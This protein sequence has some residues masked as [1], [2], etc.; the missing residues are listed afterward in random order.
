MTCRQLYIFAVWAVLL[1]GLVA[2]DHSPEKKTTV[3]VVP[4]VDNASMAEAK[5]A[6]LAARDT[7]D[8]RVRWDVSRSPTAESQ[9]ELIG[10]LVAAGVDGILISCIDAEAEVL[11]EAIDQAVA[12]GVKVGTFDSD[13]PQSGRSFYIGSDNS[14]A[15]ALAAATLQALCMEAGRP[16]TGIGVFGG[17]EGDAAMQARLDAFL[18]AVPDTAA[19]LWSGD[20]LST[21]QTQVADFLTDNSQL[22]VN[23]VV[24]LSGT[25]VMSGPGNIPRLDSLCRP[26]TDNDGAAAAA[27]FFDPSGAVAE[28]VTVMPHCAAI[29]QDFGAMVSGGVDRLL[30]AIRN[31]P[32]GE[33][34]TYTPVEAVR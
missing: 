20:V 34:V 26:A 8:I 13:C 31:E 16:A 15:G 22:P 9:A 29:R 14:A 11:R 32:F 7:Y 4:K 6:A 17:V 30:K 19:V 2:C 1:L 33:T 25:A 21:G 24:F 3:A 18:T 5:A 28:F 23:G 27:V 10:K 12:A